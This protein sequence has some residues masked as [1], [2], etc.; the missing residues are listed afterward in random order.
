[1]AKKTYHVIA[2]FTDA[3]TGEEVKAGSLYEADEKRLPKLLEAEVIGDEATKA[4]IDAAKKAGEGDADE[5]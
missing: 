3:V 4:D 1:M 2:D 5:S